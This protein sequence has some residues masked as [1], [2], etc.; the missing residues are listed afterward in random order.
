MS[1]TDRPDSTRDPKRGARP[2]HPA[3]GLATAI[4]KARMIFEKEHT[5]PVPA[6]VA[7]KH[8]GFQGST[9][10]A[11]RSLAALKTYGLM[12][13]QGGDYRFTQ[14]GLSVV[15]HA[16]DEREVVARMA[17]KPDIFQ[18][19]LAKYP[20]RLPSDQTL[21]AWLVKELTFMPPAADTVI[22]ALRE[23]LE[24]ANQHG[25]G[26]NTVMQAAPAPHAAAHASSTHSAGHASPP[27][28]STGVLHV[29]SLGKGVTVELRANKALDSTQFGLL[30]KYV[31]LAEL[32]E[33]A[34]ESGGGHEE[35][36]D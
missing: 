1:D 10:P 16:D 29:W 26:Y 4:Q 22:V 12:S 5:A 34:T 15:T 30:K 31:E 24:I 17:T 20:D 27:V 3:F 11:L 6:E 2:N 13:E 9:G 19:I 28:R 32:A 35:T 36:S 25:G 21:K 8:I 14:D 33:K 23:T 18:K 7:V